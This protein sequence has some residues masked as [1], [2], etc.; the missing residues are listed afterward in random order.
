MKIHQILLAAAGLVA[1]L[2]LSGCWEDDDNEDPVPPTVSSEVPDSAGVST[3][4]FVSFIL[5]L[6]ASDESSEPSTLKESFAVPADETAEP[7]PL[8]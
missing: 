3:A 5:G 8:T 6:A 2:G 7:T 4:A 1:A